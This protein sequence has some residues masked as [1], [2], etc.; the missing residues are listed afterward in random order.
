MASILYNCGSMWFNSNPYIC[1]TQL[2]SKLSFVNW[3]RTQCYEYAAM[4]PCCSTV[5]RWENSLLHSS[6]A[7][8]DCL[9]GYKWTCYCWTISTCGGIPRNFFCRCSSFIVLTS[10]TSY[11]QCVGRERECVECR[12]RLYDRGCLCTMVQCT[13]LYTFMW[14][15]RSSW[16]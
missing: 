14:H 9:V 7:A 6:S 11:E 15:V 8:V 4:L 10:T 13:T 1:N 2:L 12:R 16:M 3:H 5:L